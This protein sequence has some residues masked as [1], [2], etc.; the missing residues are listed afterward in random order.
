MSNIYCNNKDLETKTYKTII[1]L[2]VTK[3]HN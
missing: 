1:I 3:S 2:H